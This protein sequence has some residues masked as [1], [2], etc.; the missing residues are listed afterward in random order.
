MELLI[1]DDIIAN[2]AILFVMAVGRGTGSYS[3]GSEL[4]LASGA[5]CYVPALCE[6]AH[7]SCLITCAEM[8]FHRAFAYRVAASDI[9]TAGVATVE[10]VCICI[11]IS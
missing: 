11:I 2:S 7:D 5:V 4:M 3:V 6:A 10:C 9:Y 8:A 1:F